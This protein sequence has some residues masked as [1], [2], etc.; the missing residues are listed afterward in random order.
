MNSEEKKLL[1]QMEDDVHVMMDSTDLRTV[2]KHS[3]TD[4]YFT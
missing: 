2:I 4:E 1:T 3:R